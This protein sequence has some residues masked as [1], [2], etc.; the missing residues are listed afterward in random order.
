MA[1]LG[2]AWGASHHYVAQQ[3]LGGALALEVGKAWHLFDP[4]KA[5]E[6]SKLVSAALVPVV[7]QHAMASRAF[8]NEHYQ[9]ERSAAHIVDPFLAQV[10]AL[11]T[12]EQVYQ[13]VGWA[14]KPLRDATPEQDTAPL[15][16]PARENTVAA[17]Q[18]LVAD[19][20]R[21]Q[22]V[23]NVQADR[24]ARGYAREAR[25]TA[26]WW[27]AMLATRGA[28]YGSAWSAGARTFEGIPYNSYHAHCQCQVV[29]IFQAY[30]PPAHV[31]E[32]QDMWKRATGGV[33]GKNKLVAF[34]AE[35]LGKNVDDVTVGDAH[36]HAAPL[37]VA[38]AFAGW[39]TD[40]LQQAIDNAQQMLDAKGEPLLGGQR[41][42]WIAKLKAEL[43]RRAVAV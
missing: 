4:A 36:N 11:P 25:P 14:T 12:R 28:A 33:Y 39:S 13:Y 29:P 40:R 38:P 5:V 43:S 20:G 26:C 21:Q 30:E 23:D 19:T 2:A 15:L 17:L 37:E 24:K 22:M 16:V 34:K 41:A 32:W 35:F 10:T 6:S 9:A 18:K 27:C 3:V 31:R 7:Q 8:A 1:T 42:E